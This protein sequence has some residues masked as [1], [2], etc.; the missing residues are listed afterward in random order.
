MEST[1]PPFPAGVRLTAPV[2]ESLAPIVSPEALAFV[3]SLVRKF[4][5]PLDDLLAR[6][7]ETQAAFDAGR[8]PHF[9]AET[10]EIRQSDWHVAPIAPDLSDRRVEI[11]GPLE[12]KMVINALN[13][14]ASV[15]MADARRSA[16][17]RA[18]RNCS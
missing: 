6:R 16:P 9:L 17:P 15:F 3:A 11:T 8:T 13:S 2:P 18:G 1:A 12:R 5:D 4:R 14:G 10:R 7:R